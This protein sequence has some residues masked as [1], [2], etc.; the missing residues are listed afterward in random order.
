MDEQPKVGRRAFLAASAAGAAAW[1]GGVPFDT[2][3]V[4]GGLGD[5]P[6]DGARRP[7][8]SGPLEL[9]RLVRAPSTPTGVTISRHGRVF[10]FMPRYDTRVSYAVGEVAGDG[11]VTPYPD[12]PTNRLDPRRPQDTFAYVPN[13][14]VD[15]QDRLW[16]VDAGLLVASGP[17][18]RTAAKLVCLDLATD[19]VVR[20]IP[21]GDALAPTSSLNDLRV[22]SGRGR[23]EVAYVT[24][25]GTDGLGAIVA[26][27]LATGRCVR[28]LAGHSSTTSQDG[29]VRLIEGRQFLLRGADGTVRPVR[30]GAN[31]I[32]LSPDGR[33]LYYA[34][35]M[36]RHLYSVDAATLLDPA[37]DVAAVADAVRD[38]GEK[39]ITGGILTD[40]DDRIYLTLQEL[41]AVGRRERDGTLTVLA[42]DPRLVWPDTMWI[43]ED[44]WLYVMAA[45]AN[46]RPEYNGGVDRQRPPYALLRMRV[47]AGPA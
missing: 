28:R 27:D 35:F 21:L 14:V 30:S 13:G 19:R 23:G 43:T 33:R 47:N 20:V 12:V 29:V 46:R 24:D 22:E 37:S 4:V 7:A 10:V 45:Q 38:L 3:P 36:G 9:A 11:S 26:V 17:L 6:A 8:V 39:G 31:A 2:L 5:G 25:Q 44:G 32:A 16:L 42:T 41:N 1:G 18:V 40:A 34:P 15:G